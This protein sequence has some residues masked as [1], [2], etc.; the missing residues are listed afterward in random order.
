MLF[1]TYA[2][3]EHVPLS[4]SGTSHTSE[5]L[6]CSC[7]PPVLTILYNI[8]KVPLNCNISTIVGQ[9]PIDFQCD[10]Q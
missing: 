2:G 1:V 4:H 8:R 6:V 10:A 7:R 9:L 3:Q 5:T